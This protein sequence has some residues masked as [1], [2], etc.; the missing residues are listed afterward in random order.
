MRQ[1]SDV[2]VGS[3][4]SFQLD[5]FVPGEVYYKDVQMK[6]DSGYSGSVSLKIQ[7]LVDEYS[8]LLEH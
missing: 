6:S 5:Q 4:Q 1:Q 2:M 7:Y 8:D 3:R